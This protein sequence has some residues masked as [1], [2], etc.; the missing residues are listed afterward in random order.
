MSGGQSA[1]GGEASRPSEECGS[2]LQERDEHGLMVA[3]GDGRGD[4][5]L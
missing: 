1:S 3:G 2:R 4:E 5:G